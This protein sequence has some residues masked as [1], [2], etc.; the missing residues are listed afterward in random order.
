MFEVG[1]IDVTTQSVKE[2]QAL[3]DEKLGISSQILSRTVFYGQHS[4]NEL[5][6]ATDAKF[7]EELSLV[8][9]IALWQEA[10]KLARA[11][12][13][14]AARAASEL[15]GM[16]ALRTGDI[17]KLRI[18]KDNEEKNLKSM[19]EELNAL[20]EELENES[21]RLGGSEKTFEFEFNK[22]ELRVHE[23]AD[24]LK[25]AESK[26][27]TLMKQ[28]EEDVGPLE[29]SYEDLSKSRASLIQRC[30]DGE[31]ET[32]AASL[33]VDTMK[34]K[35][36]ALGEKWDVDLSD[37][38][39]DGFIT[40]ELCPTCQQPLSDDGKG[41]SHRDL[42]ILATRD[43]E[44]AFHAFKDAQLTLDRSKADLN[45]ANKALSSRERTLKEMEDDLSRQK[46]RW[47]TELAQCE[48]DVATKRAELQRRSDEFSVVARKV[49]QFASSRTLET[50]LSNNKAA[51]TFAGSALEALETE[52]CEGEYL[53]ANLTSQL[54][55][56]NRRE[57]NMM[58]LGEAFGQRGVQ[59]YVLKNV[60]DT[61][62]LITEKYLDELSEGAQRLQLS[63]DAGD[64]ISRTPLIQGS[65]GDYRVRP[66]S[67]L[68]GG[69]WRRC[70]LALSFAFAE[71]LARRGKLRPSL[72]ILDEP[73][74][75]LDRVGRTKVG[76]LIR[77]ML[78]PQGDPGGV[79]LGGLGISTIVLILQ[80]LAAEEL[81]E[82][83]DSI[84]E[85]EKKGGASIVKV[86]IS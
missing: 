78:R 21:L 7:K 40:P 54:E 24:E 18:R 73:L 29:R 72:C 71:L 14:D 1:G 83:F 50:K 80:D 9:P 61:L 64:R 11:R 25:N 65:D 82:S 59:T 36:E 15:T 45:E 48:Q 51:I 52:L 66:L 75:H 22:L 31:R 84:D 81:E 60:V 4:L 63:L 41:H 43:I 30:Q 37:G 57:R 68:S 35:V 32:F 55:I 8:V 86:D 70:S 42:Q 46:S 47:A 69:Q 27:E 39:P 10:A 6:E 79:G 23:A 26:F 13:R 49:Q 76:H 77:K 58:D 17:E 20:V 34:E 74:T 16:I 67:T 28:R 12:A 85:V 33:K 5:L 56:E 19:Q 2:T 38:L 3:V 62:Q 44:Q 53:I